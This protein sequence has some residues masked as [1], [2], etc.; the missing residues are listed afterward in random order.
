MQNLLQIQ[1]WLDITKGKNEHKAE[2][3]KLNQVRQSQFHPQQ[4]SGS[5]LEVSLKVVSLYFLCELVNS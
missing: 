2:K 1:D 4:L 5:L 3:C